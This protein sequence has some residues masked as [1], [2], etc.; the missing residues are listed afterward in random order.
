[1][2]LPVADIHCDL[3]SYLEDA[4]GADEMGSEIGC[5]VPFLQ[6]GNV[7]LQVMAIFSAT[8]KGS[9]EQAFNKVSYLKILS[10]NNHTN[11]CM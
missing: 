9:S 11:Y 8:E 3:L 2:N 4:E 6:Q 10:T 1:M 7:R 5:A